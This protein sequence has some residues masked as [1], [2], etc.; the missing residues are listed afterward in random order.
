MSPGQYSDAVNYPS[1]AAEALTEMYR[2]V[3]PL[4][5]DSS[6]VA[7]R[8]VLVR[9]LVMPHDLARSRDCIDIIAGCAPGCAINVMGQYR[10]AY[11]AREYPEL[12]D[13]VEPDRIERLR[14]YAEQKGLV[15]VDH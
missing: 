10:P 12:L 15:R 3:G 4:R 13:T 11:R 14:L 9:H 2:Q 7:T 6:G 5:I 8:G 1:I